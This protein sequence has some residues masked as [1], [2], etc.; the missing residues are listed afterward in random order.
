MQNPAE[1]PRTEKTEELKRTKTEI[2]GDLQA[3]LPSKLKLDMDLIPATVTWIR[4]KGLQCW[5]LGSAGG[6]EKNFLEE[7]NQMNRQSATANWSK[8]HWMVTFL[9]FPGK[10][11]F[12]VKADRR[13]LLLAR[14]S[15]LV[16]LG[17]V[18][19]G[20]LARTCLA[21]LKGN[22]HQPF[23]GS[24]TKTNHDAVDLELRCMALAY[25]TQKGTGTL[26]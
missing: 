22:H 6:G 25:R 18:S 9:Q 17:G 26:W 23:V 10:H 1:K 16:R 11:S 3:I 20:S 5:C 21:R 8:W 12:P 13:S 2:N 4:G 24:S 7:G 15:S 14:Q 19:A